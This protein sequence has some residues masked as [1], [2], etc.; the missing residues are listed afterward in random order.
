MYLGYVRS[1]L[2]NNL[3]LQSICSTN[4]Q[5]SLD[6]VQNEAVKFISGGIKSSPIAACEIDSNVEPIC[7]CREATVV[8]MVE[9]YRSCDKD[10]PNRKILD[11]WSPNDDI[12][13]KSIMKVEKILQEKHHLPTNR[14]KNSP[15]SKDVPPNRIILTPVIRLGLIEEVSKANTDP[16]DLQPY[17]VKTIMSYPEHFHH[18]YTDG[19]AFKGARIDF[20]DKTCD[21]LSE[22]CVAHCDNF[23]AETLALD[24]TLKKLT[25]T[26]E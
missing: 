14:D 4:L 3:A 12:K 23:E 15:I 2:E 7:F 22:L 9:R 18:I 20:C 11:S 1:T 6:R 26:F 5:Q 19:S 24:Y 16:I 10:K 8:E 25:K 21:E 17:G 13:Q